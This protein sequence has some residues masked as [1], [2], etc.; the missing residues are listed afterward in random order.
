[1]QYK[2]IIIVGASSGIGQGLARSYAQRDCKIGITGR[3]KELLEEIRKEN[4]DKF[5]VSAFDINEE[6]MEQR[7]LEL[8]DKLGG[9]DLLIISAGI[10]YRNPDMDV[11]LEMRT[12]QTNVVGFTKVL[13]FG[14]DFFKKQGCGHIVGISSIAGIR[15]IDLCPAYSASKGF[16][17]LYLESLRRKSKKEKL[18]IIVSTIIPGFVDTVMARGKKKHIFWKAS[19]E[20]A[21]SQI[22]RAIDKKKNKVYV[23]KRWRGIAWV[24]R[25]MPD[26]IFE[27]L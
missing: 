7:L 22:I 25:R 1:M 3:R 13:L 24:L 15:G 6:G 4:P 26:W 5:V 20:K 23:T 8:A 9:L 11:S 19:V 10:G 16:E 27:N 21:A 2:K 12:I 14:F 18:N 17:A